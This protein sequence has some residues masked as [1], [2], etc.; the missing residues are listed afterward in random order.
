METADHGTILYNGE[1]VSYFHGKNANISVN[2]CKSYFRI[3]KQVLILVNLYWKLCRK[4]LND[5]KI[6]T[7]K[8]RQEKAL[9]YLEHVGIDGDIL[10]C[11]PPQLST[12]QRQ[13]IAIARA[14]VVEPDIL[15]CDEAISALDMILQKQILEL[16]LNL[17]KSIG[18]AYIMI[19]HDIQVIRH[20]CERVAIMDKGSFMDILHTNQLTAQTENTYIIHLLNSEL[21]AVGIS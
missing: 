1:N 14:L 20:T 18:F 6:G 7:T 2:P 19:S 21:Y 9:F 5:L 11:C 17:Q 10:K 16:L 12:G 13:K 8:E 4:P 3:Q 15:I